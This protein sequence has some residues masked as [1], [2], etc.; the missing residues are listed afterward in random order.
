MI[1]I[2]QCVLF[3][4]AFLILDMARA[5]KPRLVLFL[6]VDHLRGDTFL[7]M[8]ERF[9]EGGFR[10]L[11]EHGAVYEKAE[12][13]HA[14][15]HTSCGHAT[16][17]T[18]ANPREHGVIANEWYDTDSGTL[19]YCTGDPAE[20]DT[21][22]TR[23]KGSI[24]PRNLLMDA[25][26]DVLA[27]AQGPEARIFAVSMKDRSA[28]LISGHRGKAFW[29]NARAGGFKSSTYYYQELPAWAVAWN[30]EKRADQWR[31]AEWT[32]LHDAASYVHGSEDDRPHEQSRNALGRTFPHRMRNV[33]PQFY[34][35]A[36]AMTPFGD[37]L[38]LDFARA[39]IAHEALG[40]DDTTDVLSIS[41]TATDYIGHT[42]GANSLEYEDN[43]LRLDR[44][45]AEFLND[46]DRHVG[47]SRT[48]IA[49]SA[50]H[51][52]GD[53]PERLWAEREA[54]GQLPP[55]N[56]RDYANN[57]L[58]ERLGVA[59]DL[60]VAVE[61]PFFYLDRTAC[62]TAKVSPDAAADALASVLKA[63]PEV[64][65]AVTRRQFLSDDLPPNPL[66]DKLRR[67]FHPQ[68]GGD[69]YVVEKEGWRLFIVEEK[70]GGTHGTP[71]REDSHVP[72]VMAGPGIAPQRIARPAGPEDIAP[73]LAAL[74]GISAPQGA[75][76]TP[77]SE[78]LGTR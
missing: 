68:R 47:L 38:T 70:N 13:R 74:L 40:T 11:L 71:W 20:S 31:D 36:L 69:V 8:Q 32:L 59:E 55:A 57:T 76:G 37:Q 62:A 35:G 53:I 67:S 26:S 39:L 58:R 2:L 78:V 46:L 77:L 66:G 41:L 60:V 42:F 1:R 24:S 51:G 3:A 10:Y 63:R 49:L 45:L 43:L 72:L 64:E 27:A 56:V 28:A 6:V 50:D 44:A 18:G 29:F 4:A 17:V 33:P 52:G 30:A 25:W 65:T 61:K 34:Y 54:A 14:T 19:I 21:G 22:E 75:T 16:L 7:H 12:Y 48:I 5:E 15:T 23:G 73:T 9:G